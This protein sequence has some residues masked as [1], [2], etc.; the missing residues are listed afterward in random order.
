L[1]KVGLPPHLEAIINGESLFNDGIGVVI[2]LHVAIVHSS[3]L[4]PTATIAILVCLVA[5]CVSVNISLSAL[6]LIGA[7]EAVDLGVAL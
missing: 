7:L 6:S 4:L 3:D 5:R 1:G 2:G